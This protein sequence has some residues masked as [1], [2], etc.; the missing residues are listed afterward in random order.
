MRA[1][2]DEIALNSLGVYPDEAAMNY[3][4]F[5]RTAKAYAE[6]GADFSKFAGERAGKENRQAKAYQCGQFPIWL[7]RFKLGEQKEALM[8]ELQLRFS[9]PDSSTHE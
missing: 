2:G 6:T 1:S 8:P 9:K 3:M 7:C 4:R 5:M